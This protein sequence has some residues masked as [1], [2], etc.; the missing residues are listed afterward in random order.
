MEIR[1]LFMRRSD[2]EYLQQL[3][4]IDA[5]ERLGLGYHFGEEIK[6]FLGD[7]DGKKLEVILE[8]DL[9]ATALHFK[10]M[11]LHGANVSQGENYTIHI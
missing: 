3:E 7:H 4:L 9:Y 5:L 1:H 8:D 10:L 11:R 2:V 6:S